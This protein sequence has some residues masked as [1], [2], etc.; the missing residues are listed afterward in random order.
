MS[1]EQ[2]KDNQK[3]LI[4]IFC[5]LGILVLIPLLT[6]KDDP[7]VKSHIKQGLVLLIAEVSGMFIS[8][9]PLFGWILGP[10]LTITFIVLSI[11]GIINVLNGQEKDLPLIGKY[12]KNFN[13]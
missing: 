13:I 1:Q 7:F 2:K 12:G 8:V 9:I 4:A 11:I 3:N 5:Y 10:F 6:K